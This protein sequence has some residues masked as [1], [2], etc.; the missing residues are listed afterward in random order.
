MNTRI[1]GYDYYSQAPPLTGSENPKSEKLKES[2]MKYGEWTMGQ[3]EA[4][5]NKLGGMDIAL[6]ILRGAIGMTV[7]MKVNFINHTFTVMVDETLSVEEAVKAGHFNWSNE[8]I[9]SVKFP[10]PAKGQKS[11]RE[12]V[13][14]Q[15]D[16]NMSSEAV[17]VEM[18]KV[19]YKSA[20]IWDLLGLAVKEPDLQRKFPV[21][22][23][24]SV[25]ELLGF[26]RVA[27]L[28]GGSGARE[29]GLFCFGSGWHGNY[30]FAGVRK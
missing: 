25:C 30:R 1:F 29:L 4:L 26:R 28:C 17:I 12:V 2:A 21:V 24:G 14:F 7:T 11:E 6:G 13:L 19:G 15:F 8:N 27:Y 9:T 20:T 3:T 22:A 16:K 18:D 23:L 5:I 10:K